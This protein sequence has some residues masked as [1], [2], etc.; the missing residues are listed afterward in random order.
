MHTGC[1]V[2]RPPEMLAWD[3]F[4]ERV[5]TLSRVTNSR[6]QLKSVNRI[7][8]CRLRGRSVPDPYG[9]CGLW[10]PFAE[11]VDLGSTVSRF[12]HLAVLASMS[13]PCYCPGERRY[14]VPS[15]TQLNT[16]AWPCSTTLGGSTGGSLRRTY[17]K[18]LPSEC[19]SQCRDVDGGFLSSWGTWR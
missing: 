4:V 6:R 16:W 8:T 7:I 9:R 10:V 17:Q 2:C 19:K 11:C 18:L 13:T 1:S 14:R 5:R 3:M 12:S 15:D